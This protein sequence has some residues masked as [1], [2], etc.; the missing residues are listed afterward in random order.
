MK[1]LA[2]VGEKS[3]NITLRKA[4]YKNKKFAATAK[5]DSSFEIFVGAQFNFKD[6]DKNYLIH[7]TV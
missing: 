5:Y 2:S 7:N 6:N 4:F 1:L 3:H